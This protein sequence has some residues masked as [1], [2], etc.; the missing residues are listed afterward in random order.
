MRVYYC[1]KCETR[2][3]E[4]DVAAGKAVLLDNDH[5]YC[6][7]CVPAE[8]QIA[9]AAPSTKKPITKQFGLPSSTTAPRRLPTHSYPNLN[10]AV[11]SNS[12]N[13]AVTDNRPL[14]SGIKRGVPPPPKAFPMSYVVLGGGVAI[15][16][17]IAMLY[18]LGIIGD[19]PKHVAPPVVKAPVPAPI[20]ADTPDAPPRN[21]FE[22]MAR[23]HKRDFDPEQAKGRAARKLVEANDFFAKNPQDPWM[24]A[25]MLGQVAKDTPAGNDADK[26]L[27]G[28]KYPEDKDQSA[29]WYRDW[30]FTTTGATTNLLYEFDRKKNVLQTIPPTGKSK[31]LFNRKVTVP[32]DRPHFSLTVR[33]ENKQSCGVAIEIDDKEIYSETIQG[34]A[35][36]TID[37]DLS[38]LKGMPLSVQLVHS[39]PGTN[40]PALYW[41][42]PVFRD[43]SDTNAKVVK[44]D[45]A[46]PVDPGTKAPV[47]MTVRKF[48][49]PTDWKA[50]A[51]WAT[52]VDLLG[53]F[54]AKSDAVAGDWSRDKNDLI[55]KKANNARVAIAYRLPDQYDIRARFKRRNGNGD[56]A[57]ILNYFGKPF[58]WSLGADNNKAFLF[59]RVGGKKFDGNPTFIRVR[60]ALKNNTTYTT[61]V[62][63]R[64]DR[65]S[66]YVNDR[67]VDE[68][69]PSMGELEIDP[70]WRISEN[71]S[72]GVGTWQSEAVFYSLQV[73]EAK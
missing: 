62:E 73:V 6:R 66:A 70:G 28:L 33:C 4:E 1:D 5:T 42:P 58:M 17:L 24:F 47:E 48:I 39:S 51:A 63:V 65:I 61:L 67:L 56:V 10:N 22:E 36:R 31:T 8:S 46:T 57:L 26:L 69:T 2:L 34:S 23:E 71:K 20:A 15:L 3:S 11:R 72:I 68:W 53:L 29:G 45:S 14:G 60:E 21:M 25:E 40:N 7:A 37:L 64:K 54:D 44:I 16:S 41:A 27:K 49:A 32:D 55:S 43:N 19:P 38:A 9:G 52:P 12:R 35:W 18:A 13:A 30:S 50:S 59:Y